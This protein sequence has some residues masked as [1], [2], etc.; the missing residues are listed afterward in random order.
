VLG[1]GRS[2]V[3]ILERGLV[4]VGVDWAERVIGTIEKI[5]VIE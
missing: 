2:V 5:V 3:P 1:V 4:L